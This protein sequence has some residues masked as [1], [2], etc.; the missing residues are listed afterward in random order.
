MGH[1]GLRFVLTRVAG[2][3]VTE[4]PTTHTLRLY[5]PEYV[6]SHDAHA[7]VSALVGKL[8]ARR[9]PSVVVA[10]MQDVR[11]FDAF[12]PVVA[13]RAALAAVEKIAHVHLV[14]RSAH[15]RIAAIAAARIIGLSYTLH[16]DEPALSPST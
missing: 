11:R 9:A 14:V 5:F 15:V 8:N 2:W 7:G 3:S 10:A 6:S 1:G 13:A 16:T 4:D 12:A